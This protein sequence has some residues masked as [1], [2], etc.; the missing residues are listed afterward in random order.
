MH[1]ANAAG[2]EHRDIGQRRADHRRSDRRRP[3]GAGRQRH[4]KIAATDLDHRLGSREMLQIVV[5][6][7]D[8][9][10]PV[11]HRDGCRDGAAVAHGLFDKARGFDITGQGIPWE[12]MVDS[13]ATTA[14][15]AWSASA[16]R[17]E[18]QGNRACREVHP[19]FSKSPARSMTHISTQRR[20]L[21]SHSSRP[22]KRRKRAPSSWPPPCHGHRS[23]QRSRLRSARRPRPS[24][25]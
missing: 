8:L 11:Q 2:S 20:I 25:H 13:R 16:T 12:M 4:G 5:V 22:P 17:D 18:W 14:F 7:A 9:D 3:I 23:G 24:L 15:L 10:A 19:V 21:P 1:A 6:Q